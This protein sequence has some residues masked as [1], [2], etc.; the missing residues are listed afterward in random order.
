MGA[1]AGELQVDEGVV[2][3]CLNVDTLS[4]PCK[5]FLQ[6]SDRQGG[7]PG[8]SRNKPAINIDVDMLIVR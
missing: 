3:A 4:P 8:K 6:V 1:C 7:V 2:G 5:R